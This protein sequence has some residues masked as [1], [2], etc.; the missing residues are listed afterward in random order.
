MA[1]GKF[2]TFFANKCLAIFY[3]LSMDFRFGC[4]CRDIQPSTRTFEMQP[5][6]PLIRIAAATLILTCLPAFAQSAA[7]FQV[8][9]KQIQELQ[10]KVNKLQKEQADSTVSYSGSAAAAASIEE[11]KIKLAAGVTELKLY[12]DLR[13]RYQY[14]QFHPVI[15]FPNL[16]T[17]DRNRFRFRLRIGADVQLGDQFFAGVTLATGQAADSNNQTYTEGYDNYNIYIDK[18]FAGWTPNDWL[19]IILGKQA[20]PFY[21]TD[22]VWG[23]D[24][25]PAGAVEI[26]DLSNA[27]MPDDSRLSL[28]LIS[29]QGIFYG[30]SSFSVGSDTAGQFV[31]QL[32]GTYSFNKNFSVTF[33]P[34]FMIYTAA[35]LTG[36]QNSQ[37]FSKP[38]DVLI[39]PNGVQVQTTNSTTNTET[40]KYDATGKPSITLTPVNNTTTVTTTTPVTGPTRTVTTTT[41]NN[42][43]QVTIPFGAKGN[44]L[45]QNAK[46]AN[47]TFVTTSTV[48]RGTTTVTTPTGAAPAQETRDLAIITAP[49]DISFKLGGIATKVYWDFAYNTEGS[50]RAVNEY[51]LSN[52][53][54]EDDVA[55]L[56]GVQLGENNRAGDWS[57]Y[58][59]YRQVGMD[60]IDPN[61]NDTNF[62][63][64][65]LNVQGIKIGVA[66]NFTDSLVGDITYFK[67]WFLRSGLTGGEAT[68]GAQLAN[69]KSVDVLQVDLNLKF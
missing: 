31:E 16:A 5:L 50:S 64:S 45:K 34:G 63:L 3:C 66:Y 14:D 36:L 32:K 26:V 1:C 54:S 4:G 13:F 52:H 29:M 53:S 22:L 2:G 19:T 41:S 10:A 58:A 7:D 65:Y 68:G 67:S 60:A 39:A 38:T 59:N 27:F 23:P 25:T 35:S 51:F 15:D 33:A 40:I 47:K 30:G 56:A 12:G 18:A 69:A 48:G 11:N 43:T 17:D 24:I 21:T 28:H 55:W 61:L 44:D 6:A 20:N 9:E 42:Q 57:L 8:L 37:N 62:A 46:L 49:G